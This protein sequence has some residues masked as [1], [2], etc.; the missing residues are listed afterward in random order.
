MTPSGGDAEAAGAA[1]TAKAAAT[2]ADA[3]QTAPRTGVERRALD[4]ATSPDAEQYRHSSAAAPRGGRGPSFPPPSARRR[5]REG[6]VA[7]GTPATVRGPLSG[8]AI[9]WVDDNP[10]TYRELARRHAEG[11]R[12]AGDTTFSPSDPAATAKRRS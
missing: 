7:T 10:R 9:W 4:M 6:T 8:S 3:A 12:P 11:A 5:C 2:A 1:T